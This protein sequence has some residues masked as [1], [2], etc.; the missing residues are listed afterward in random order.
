MGSGESRSRMTKQRPTRISFFGHFGTPNFGNEATLLAIVSRLRLLFPTCEFCCICSYPENVIATNEIEAVPH[1]VRSVRIW[2]RQVPLGRR[3]WMAAIGLS[4]EPR[5]YV[6]AWRT[7]KGTDMFIVPG[8]GL[9]TDA[10]ALA[11]WGPYGVFKWSLMARLSGCRVMFVSVGAGPVRSTPGRFLVKSALSLADYRS[12]RDTPSKKVLESLGLRTKDDRIY[13]DLVFGLSPPVLPMVADRARRRVVGLGLMEYAG[14]YSV[15]NP[16]RDTYDLYLESLAVFVRWLLDH[17]YDVKLLLGDGDTRVIDDLR[18][19]LPKH[20]G[21][22]AAERVSDHPAN[23][24]PELLSHLSATDF[25]VATRFHNILMS[26][27]LNK[28]VIAISFHH[29]C[30]S[31]MSDMGLSEYCHD[32]NQMNADTL[33]KQFQAAVRNS[34]D[35]KQAILQRVETSRRSLDEQYEFLFGDFTNELRASDARSS[36]T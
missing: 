12:Y 9:I 32:I 18:A 35:V 11:G 25:V 17:E 36:A 24:V 23:S 15:A 6:R 28:P 29:K 19:A 7:L 3:L 21:H 1:T 8:T 34:N 20:V 10:F 13:P 33:I 31:L 4:Q 2:N 30:S 5:E 27:L 16:T 14:K 26:L 22:H